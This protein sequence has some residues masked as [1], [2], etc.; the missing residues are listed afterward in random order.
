MNN[1]KMTIRLVGI[2]VLT[3]L[4]PQLT[5]CAVGQH[6]KRESDNAG[7]ES[8][9]SLGAGESTG[10]EGTYKKGAVDPASAK[11]SPV[12]GDGYELI[13]G[14]GSPINVNAAYRTPVV[15]GA[16]G[17]TVLNFET[18]MSVK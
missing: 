4:V 2:L 1:S 14:R 13:A 18:P 5:S 16:E 17:S 3:L 7:D 8:V 6:I 10:T 15:N 11:T 12:T 9:V